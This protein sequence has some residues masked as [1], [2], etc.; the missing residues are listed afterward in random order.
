[1]ID[2]VIMIDPVTMYWDFPDLK[3]KEDPKTL[4]VRHISTKTIFKDKS[5]NETSY[6]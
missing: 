5:A 4:M 3:N 6:T 2:P 1:M